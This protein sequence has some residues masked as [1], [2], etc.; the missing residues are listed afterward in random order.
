MGDANHVSGDARVTQAHNA[1]VTKQV[2]YI[3]WVEEK[4][5]AW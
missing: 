4:N 3:Q 2:I 5:G 1:S